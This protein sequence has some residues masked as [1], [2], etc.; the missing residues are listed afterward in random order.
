M[1]QEDYQEVVQAFL[2]DV[3]NPVA[4][5]R[6]NFPEDTCEIHKVDQYLFNEYVVDLLENMLKIF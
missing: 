6:V 2:E 1:L 3:V 5:D 4:D